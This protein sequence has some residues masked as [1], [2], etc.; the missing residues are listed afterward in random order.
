MANGVGARTSIFDKG[1]KMPTNVS[2]LKSELDNLP[3]RYQRENVAG[4]IRLAQR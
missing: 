1:A 2:H 4:M 3:L